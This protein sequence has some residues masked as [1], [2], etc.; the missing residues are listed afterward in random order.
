MHI[1]VYLII[2][3]SSLESSDSERYSLARVYILRTGGTGRAGGCPDGSIKTPEASLDRVLPVVSKHTA[4]VLFPSTLSHTLP[5]VSSLAGPWSS[6]QQESSPPVLSGVSEYHPWDK[7]VPSF[8]NPGHLQGSVRPQ[9]SSKLPAP[10]VCPAVSNGLTAGSPPASDGFSPQV[11][12]RRELCR[13]CPMGD[14]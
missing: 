1:H 4:P 8:C 9:T 2:G 13:G 11:L 7:S 14:R 10:G 6:Y 12:V 5:W 3:S